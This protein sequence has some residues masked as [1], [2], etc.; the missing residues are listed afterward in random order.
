MLTVRRWTTQVCC[1]IRQVNEAFHADAQVACG[2]IQK[3]TRLNDVFVH[4]L[5]RQ[6]CT[7]ID[8]T[9]PRHRGFGLNERIC[10]NCHRMFFHLALE[11]DFDSMDG[12]VKVWW[13]HCPATCSESSPIFRLH[14][15]YA[16]NN[17]N[18][19]IEPVRR[20]V[21]RQNEVPRYFK[22][23]CNDSGG[24]IISSRCTWHKYLNNKFYFSLGRCRWTTI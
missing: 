12:A 16:P 22:F 19:A 7:S 1:S 4:F 8:K 11:R 13:L 21:N 17:S 24:K 14:R 3:R 18:V 5:Q 9:N 2:H 20:C 23:A 10:S 6:L 15:K